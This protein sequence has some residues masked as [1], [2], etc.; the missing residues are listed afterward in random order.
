S[1]DPATALAEA[2]AAAR[3][4]DAAVVVVGTTEGSESEGH[5]RT[6]LHLGAGQ[7]ELV[8]AVLAANPD[9]VVVVNAGSPV[10]MPWRDRAGAVLLLWFPGQ[11]AGSGLADVLFGRAEPGGRLPTSWPATLSDAPVSDTR[12][13]AGVLTY[14]EGLHIGY[15]AWLRARR[16]PAYWFGH[17]LG[18]TTW[19]YEALGAPAVVGGDAGFAVRV[20]VRNTGTRRGREVVQA[21]LARA[22]SAVERPARWLAGFAAVEAAPGEVVTATVTVPARALQHWREQG[23]GWCTEA[24]EFQ[25]LVGRSAGDLPLGTALYVDPAGRAQ[26]EDEP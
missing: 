23:G 11:E 20:R 8:S 25:L 16:S 5:D 22:D 9:T 13:T 17:G 12:P 26:A 24:G 14:G 6:S 4:A 7:D 21:Y 3:A 1:P 19:E 10:T 15:R 2:A 18:Y